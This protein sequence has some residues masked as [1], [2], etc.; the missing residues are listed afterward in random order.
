MGETSRQFEERVSK[1]LAN[2]ANFKLESFVIR[3]W[4]SRHLTDTSAP[5]FKFTI[6]SCHRDALSHQI[7]EAL[8]IKEQG[9]LNMRQE[10]GT[11]EVIRVSACAYS[12]EEEAK[13][14]ERI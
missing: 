11:N 6:S 8:L 7:M 14:G 10:F 12:W 1:H 13:E 3:H 4:M 5:E 2:A 9:N